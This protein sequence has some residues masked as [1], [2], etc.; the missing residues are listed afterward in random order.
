MLEF[1]QIFVTATQMQ[2]LEIEIFN[3]GMPVPALME[4]AAGLIAQ[5][6][7][8]HY[9]LKDYRKISVLVGPGH[10]GGDALVVARELYFAGYELRL[11]RPLEKLKSL[12][13]SHWNYAQF[14][15]IPQIKDLDLFLESHLIIDGLFGFGLTRPITGDLGLLIDEL[16]E[17]GL[18]IVSIDL[19]SG[20]HTDTGEVLGTAIQATESLCL[21][22]WK[23]AY[24]QDAAAPYLGRVN[25][26]D[27]GIPSHLIAETLS[28]KNT[29]QG[30][31]QN[32]LQRFLPLGRSPLTHKYRQGHLLLIGGSQT[33]LGS[34]LLAALGA[35]ATG[36]GMLTV[37]VPE[38]LKLLVVAQLPEAL[39]IGCPEDE[40]GA[41]AQL[42]SLDFSRYQ[43]V[44]CGCGLTLTGAT[45]L[46][47]D[48]M[49]REVPL[50]LDADALNWLAEE[51][52]EVLQNR[53]FP[54]ILT[55][56]LGEFKRL[57]ADQI[58]IT[59]DRFQMTQMAAQLTGAIALLKGAKTV[60]ARPDGVTHCVTES[61]PALARGGSGDVL[62]GLIGGLL[63][64]DPDAPL[65]VAAAAAWWHAQAGILAAQTRTVAGVDGVTLA[66]FL[67]DVLQQWS[68]KST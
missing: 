48:L 64:Q 59:A 31:P 41:I 45:N 10:N 43:A 23:R 1:D 62:L 36:I 33:Y 4:K 35:R 29:I 17:S 25:R 39:V 47:P 65:E 51:D 66:E 21:G 30:I 46:M 53:H 40:T 49:P 27:F 15:G 42:P 54:T 61:T 5:Y 56:H 11:L 57:F 26:L 63:A 2:H 34:L 9:P 3:Q 16:N 20:L 6:I 24:G 28:A 32:L 14:L 67:V 18:S 22:L 19:P 13:Q 38:S 12:P 37:A 60:I 68:A 8:S 50:V 52:L 7:Q 55:P 58:P 44:A